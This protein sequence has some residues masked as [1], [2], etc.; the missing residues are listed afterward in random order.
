MNAEI[1]VAKGCLP[2]VVPYRVTALRFPRLSWSRRHRLST[3]G[4]C[5]TSDGN[6]PPWFSFCIHNR[7]CPTSRLRH[8]SSYLCVRC[9]DGVAVGPRGTF[10]WRTSQ[11]GA[12]RQIFP[13]WT[14]HWSRPSPVNCS[15]KPSNRCVGNPWLTARHGRSMP[16]AHPSVGAQGGALWLRMLSNPGGTRTGACRAI[17]ALPRRLARFW[18]SMEA[19]GKARALAPRTTS[20]VPT[21]RPACRPA[22]AVIPLYRLGRADRPL[23]STHTSAVGLGNISPH[24]MDTEGM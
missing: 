23:S 10:P 16:W 3:R 12:A 19:S 20:S 2:C 5:S 17:P 6:A 9:N 18:T 7:L 8:E 15:Q 14:T 24:G 4:P 22:S 11:A 1:A 21:R 13:P